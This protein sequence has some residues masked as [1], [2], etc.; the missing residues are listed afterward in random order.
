MKKCLLH[1]RLLPEATTWRHL[2]PILRG[3]GVINFTF[4]GGTVT[5]TESGKVQER[6]YTYF[7]ALVLASVFL[8]LSPVP[9]NAKI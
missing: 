4:L 1:I 2:N 6:L 7:K 9:R 5:L 3:R 8:T